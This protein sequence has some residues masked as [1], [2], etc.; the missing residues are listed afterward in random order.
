M[1]GRYLGASYLGAIRP[2][3]TPYIPWG[4]ARNFDGVFSS[5]RPMGG[6][7]CVMII[8]RLRGSL[9]ASMLSVEKLPSV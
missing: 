3:H 6:Q 7:E 4:P 1:Y 8:R 5:W 2:K 9:S